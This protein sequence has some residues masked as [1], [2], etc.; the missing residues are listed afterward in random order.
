MRG[1]SIFLSYFW[2]VMLM[3]K[4]VEWTVLAGETEVLGENLPRRHFVHHKSHFPHTNPTFHTRART[5]AAAVGSQRLTASAMAWPTHKPQKTNKK[6]SFRGLVVTWRVNTYSR[7]YTFQRGRE[8]LREICPTL[9]LRIELGRL[10]TRI[11]YPTAESRRIECLQ[12]RA[13]YFCY[14]CGNADIPRKRG[15]TVKRKLKSLPPLT[16]FGFDNGDIIPLK[17]RHLLQQMGTWTVHR[18]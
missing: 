6:K 14:Q 5:R 16:H 7:N 18:L 8:N 15:C 12:T 17:R 4:L 11:R 10:G 1:T 2:I 9:D 13:S 3:E